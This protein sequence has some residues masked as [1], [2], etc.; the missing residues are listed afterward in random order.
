MVDLMVSVSIIS[1]ITAIAVPNFLR[2]RISANEAAAIASLRAL[3]TAQHIY[4]RSDHDGD[5]VMEYAYYWELSRVWRRDPN[6]R[7][8][9]AELCLIDRSLANAHRW[10]SPLRPG[11]PT[12]PRNGYY[13]HDVYGYLDAANRWR[14]CGRLVGRRWL[15]LRFGFTATPAAYD[16]TGRN[17]FAV[18]DHG[19]LWQKD[20]ALEPLYRAY[21]Y[22]WFLREGQGMRAHAWTNVE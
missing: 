4:R 16:G 22:L 12:L 13:F 19:V 9:Q 8:S 21:D 3:A 15:L 14:S 17:L 6:G 20:G 10:W 1:V 11:K 5:G 7:W 2:S 18:S